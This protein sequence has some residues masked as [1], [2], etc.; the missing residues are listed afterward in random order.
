MGQDRG[1]EKLLLSPPKLFGMNKYK[2]SQ[3]L[4][5]KRKKK[6]RECCYLSEIPHH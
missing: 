2:N 3:V 6:E 5:L 1:E 4:K